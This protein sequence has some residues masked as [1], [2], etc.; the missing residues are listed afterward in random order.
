MGGPG[1]DFW[2]VYLHKGVDTAGNPIFNE[3]Q[4]AIAEQLRLH[5]FDRTDAI[6]SLSADIKQG[7]RIANRPVAPMNILEVKKQLAEDQLQR[8]LLQQKHNQ[9]GPSSYQVGVRAQ[10][11]DFIDINR[12]VLDHDDKVLEAILNITKKNPDIQRRVGGQLDRTGEDIT[13]GQMFDA[14]GQSIGRVDDISTQAGKDKAGVAAMDY[15][16]QHNIP[17]IRGIDKPTLSGFE[18]DKITGKN[19]T[20]PTYNYNVA[21]PNSVELLDMFRKQ[22]DNVED[23][24]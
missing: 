7:Q 3:R 14:I 17:G 12:Y 6:N 24:F 1:G 19:K 2:N 22:T 13:G 5:G 11:G 15:L 18:M 21:D 20:I 9:F 10:P 8:S 16:Q 23:L 4:R